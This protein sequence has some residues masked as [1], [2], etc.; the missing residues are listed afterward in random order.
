MRNIRHSKCVWL[1]GASA[2]V[3]G[4]AAP[5]AIAQDD[6]DESPR[7]LSTVTVTT[8]KTEQSIQDVPIAVSAFDED[9][10]DR[11]QLTGGSDLVKAVPNVSF[12]K[13]QF[14]SANFK[15]RGIGADVVAQSGDAGVGIH[16]NDVPL[17]ANRL[18]EAEFYDIERAEILRGPQ[19]TLYGRNATGGVFNLITAKPVFDEFQAD[20]SLTYG[21]YSTIK[22]KG[23]INL[24]MG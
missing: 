17:Q 24:P 3:I 9:A 10:I 15:I 23:M 19:G 14:T 1:A 12:T 4:L 8:Q 6:T 11:L 2:L 18:F 20:L 16:Q 5:A 22:T 21:N 7:T 13:G